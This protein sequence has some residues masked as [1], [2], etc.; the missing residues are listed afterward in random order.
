VGGGI[1]TNQAA[2]TQLMAHLNQLGGGSGQGTAMLM[3]PGGTMGGSLGGIVSPYA[4]PPPHMGG[5]PMG[6]MHPG[7]A[8]TLSQQ[9]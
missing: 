4:P 9:M 2:M 8:A 7:L 1:T 3:P 5:H 6:G